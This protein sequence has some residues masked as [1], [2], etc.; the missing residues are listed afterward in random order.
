[1]G[2]WYRNLIFPS[3]EFLIRSATEH[4][5]LVLTWEDAVNGKKII[6]YQSNTSK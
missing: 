5:P 2:L 1:M 4:K 6:L 3:Q